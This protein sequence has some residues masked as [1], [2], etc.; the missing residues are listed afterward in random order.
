MNWIWDHCIRRQFNDQI[1]DYN[2][3]SEDEMIAIAQDY[4]QDQMEQRSDID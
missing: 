2:A 4:A 3:I 1:Q